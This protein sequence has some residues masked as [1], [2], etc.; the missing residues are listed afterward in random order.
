MLNAFCRVALSV[1]FSVLAI[2][3]ARVFFRASN[4]NARICSGVHGRRFVVFLA[5]KNSLLWKGDVVAL[6]V[7]KN[8]AKKRSAWINSN[9]CLE[10]KIKK[11]P[12]FRNTQIGI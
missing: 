6:R 7:N 12:P 9:F 3:A 1:R 4:V 10:Y 2:L 11:T 5:I 8:N